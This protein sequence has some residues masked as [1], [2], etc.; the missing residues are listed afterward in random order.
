MV[1]L[2]GNYSDR[3]FQTNEIW[4]IKSVIFEKKIFMI[5]FTKSEVKIKIKEPFLPNC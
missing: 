3:N 2:C 1:V 5:H 4:K